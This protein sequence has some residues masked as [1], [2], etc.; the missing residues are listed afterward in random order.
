M[1]VIIIIGGGPRPNATLYTL[2]PV[3]TASPSPTQ[4]AIMDGN[5]CLGV[6]EKQSYAEAILPLIQRGE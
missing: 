6:F 1:S 5:E 4:Y 2:S 3:N